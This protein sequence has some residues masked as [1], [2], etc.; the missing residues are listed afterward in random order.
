MSCTAHCPASKYGPNMLWLTP[1]CAH[2]NPLKDERD[3][4]QKGCAELRN[5]FEQG[6]APGLSSVVHEQPPGKA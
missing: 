5:L 1:Q 6:M 2:H 3:D 4:H